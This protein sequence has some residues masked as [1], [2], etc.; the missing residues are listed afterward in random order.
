MLRKQLL[1]AQ[2]IAISHYFL[3]SP[4]SSFWLRSSFVH[5]CCFNGCG[6]ISLSHQVFRLKQ[7]LRICGGK[8]ASVYPFPRPPTHVGASGTGS[9]LMVVDT[10]VVFLDLNI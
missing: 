6:A 8:F 10:D 2:L 4:L 1:T 9:A 3:I 7:S 5:S